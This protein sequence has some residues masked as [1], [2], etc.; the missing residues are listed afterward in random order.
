MARNRSTSQ[1]PDPVR[2]RIAEQHAAE[3][4]A[5][6][7]AT[8]AGTAEH[9]LDVERLALRIADQL[10][11]SGE[12]RKSVGIAARLHD[13]GK[14]A[15]PGSLLEKPAA[16]SG[17]E[18]AL[19]R[20]H[21]VLGERLLVGGNLDDVPRY[22]RHSHERWDGGGYPDGL[23]G[24]EIPLASR[25]IFCADAYD[26]ICTNRPY[27]RGVSPAEG[28]AEIRRSSGTQFDPRVVEALARAVRPQL[29]GRSSGVE[30]R[31]HARLLAAMAVFSIG[32]IGTAGAAVTN[33]R[34]PTI[35]SPTTAP[36]ASLIAQAPSPS[37]GLTPP[38][39][40]G[41]TGGARKNPKHAKRAG[42]GDHGGGGRIG[43]GRIGAVQGPAG[44][45]QGPAGPH[46]GSAPQNSPGTGP[47][48]GAPANAGGQPG[49]G[50]LPLPIQV[51]GLNLPNPNSLLQGLPLV[52]GTDKH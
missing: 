52:S 41:R 20:D 42:I 15:L 34:G 26:A 5:M 16:L 2:R 30:R 17:D 28:L 19:M 46:Q 18:W 31:P 51:P 7:L 13:I 3:I 45:G 50:T 11:L 44:A 40:S 10:G 38:F 25:I 6:L 43:S 47:A 36:P 29:Y 1:H 48:G 14:A 24:E 4:D 9:S 22:V 37:G 32:A 35:A 12:E 33:G 23:R 49:Q 39:S 21:T 8:G 27:R